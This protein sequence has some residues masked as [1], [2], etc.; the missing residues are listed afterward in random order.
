[1]NANYEINV[2]REVFKHCWAMFN[3]V[4]KDQSDVGWENCVSEANAINQLYNEELYEKIVL[5]VVEEAE[6]EFKLPENEKCAA[7]HSAKKAFNEAWVLFKGIFISQ[8]DNKEDLIKEYRTSNPGVFALK[9]SSSIYTAY[10][11]MEEEVSFLAVVYPFIDKFNKGISDS[12]KNTAYTMAENMIQLYPQYMC[13]ILK[14]YSDLR[15]KAA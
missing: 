10:C 9:L 6:S 11:N 3:A 15:K 4:R 2:A 12:E 1:M 8:A 14:L 13:Q 7:Y 5:A